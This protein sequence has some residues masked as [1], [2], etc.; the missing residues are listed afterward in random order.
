MYRAILKAL[1]RLCDYALH[2]VDV[3][4][5]I[6]LFWLRFVISCTAYVS[7]LIPYELTM[8]PMDRA[9][10]ATTIAKRCELLCEVVFA[11]DVWFSWHIRESPDAME[12]Y[13]E[14]LRRLYRKER[15]YWDLIATIPVYDMLSCS[16]A[17]RGSKC[18]AASRFST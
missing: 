13:D 10:A 9:T 12:L 16:N 15:M 4:S 8:D 17:V 6:H 2:G 1:S 18:C 5:Q 3:Q 7:I 11:L 14:N